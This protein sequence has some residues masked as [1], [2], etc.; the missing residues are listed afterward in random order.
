MGDAHFFGPEGVKDNSMNA[1]SLRVM[2]KRREI[3]NRITRF[4]TTTLRIR[5]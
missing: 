3:H 1:G 4:F 2:K 5:I